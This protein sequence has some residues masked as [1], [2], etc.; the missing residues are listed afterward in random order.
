[1]PLPTLLRA[2]SLRLSSPSEDSFILHICFPGEMTYINAL[3]DSG[4]SVNFIDLALASKHPLLRCLLQKPIDLELF[5]GELT[6]G[7]SITHDLTTP[8]LYANGV[9]HTV[10][11][12]E[13]KL[14]HSNP[15]VLGLKWLR[16]INPD[17]DWASLSLVFQKER[18]AGAIPMFRLGK[19]YKTTI[20]EVTDEDHPM[21]PPREGPL[22][23]D[24]DEPGNDETK[25]T[26]TKTPK[27]PP[28]PTPKDQQP[29][30]KDAPW[31][32]S[33]PTSLDNSFPILKDAPLNANIDIKIIGAAP[34][35]RLIQEG[36]EVYQL[37]I[38]PVSPHETLC[39]ETT[40][41]SE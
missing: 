23:P 16:D 35:A 40:Q 10:T 30:P 29:A 11:F 32:D 5:N 2:V 37:H 17:I 39:M 36:M 25:P 28:K 14:H 22:F 31:D 41:N 19:N 38:S 34:F 18:L 15:I 20:K 27:V 13:T 7:G 21:Q 12:H 3:I 9:Q 6:S 24:N 4:A 8:I 33:Y 1:M 26:P